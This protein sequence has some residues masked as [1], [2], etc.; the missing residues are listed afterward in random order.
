MRLGAWNDLSHWP[1]LQ[2]AKADLQ[3]LKWKVSVL[4][5]KPPLDQMSEELC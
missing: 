4:V 3:I 1:A 5:Q 2:R